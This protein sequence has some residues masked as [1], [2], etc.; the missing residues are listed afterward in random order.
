MSNDVSI[1]LDFVLS[2]GSEESLPD[3]R[4]DKSGSG[5]FAYEAA[6]RLKQEIDDDAL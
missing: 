2:C 1:I 5:D 4:A 6:L 3:M